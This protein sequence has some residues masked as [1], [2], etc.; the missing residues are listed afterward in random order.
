MISG[1]E[2]V[3]NIVYIYCILFVTLIY[4]VIPTLLKDWV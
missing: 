3:Q 4:V 2:H 1:D